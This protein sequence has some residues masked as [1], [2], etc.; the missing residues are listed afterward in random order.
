MV[1]VEQLFRRFPRVVRDI[2]KLCGK[3]IALEMAG[4]HT[5]LDKG[6]LDALAE[7]LTHLVATP[8]IMAS[9]LP[10]SASARESPL[11]ALFS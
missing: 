11:V 8:L 3:D 1:P 4:E 9:S 7:P 5:D 10:R 2:A 6:I